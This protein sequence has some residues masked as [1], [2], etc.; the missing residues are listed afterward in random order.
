MNAAE[1]TQLNGMFM[2]FIEMAIEYVNKPNADL[3]ACYTIGIIHEM[4]KLERVSFM[5]YIK[6][7]WNAY[8]MD[9]ING[10]YCYI[11]CTPIVYQSWEDYET[12]VSEAE[13]DKQTTKDIFDK[14]GIEYEEENGILKTKFYRILKMDYAIDEIVSSGIVPKAAYKLNPVSGN[15]C[16][17]ACE[18]HF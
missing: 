9:I 8:T 14:H 15:M 4:N 17:Y 18:M 11:K 13:Q 5:E 3:D 12:E 1:I 6:E 16:E 7:Y 10:D 2:D